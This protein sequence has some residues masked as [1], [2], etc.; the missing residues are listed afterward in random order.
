[1]VG[2]QLTV[3]ISQGLLFIALARALGPSEFGVLAGVLAISSMILPF[4]G[5]GA[6]NVMIKRFAQ[7]TGHLNTYYGNA[8]FV[9]WISA[10]I[11]IPI[12]I[13]ACIYLFE[14]TASIELVVLIC[15]SEVLFT[16][17]VDV[18]AHVHIAQERHRY[19]GLLYAVHSLA[20]LSFAL[21][22]LLMPILRTAEVWAI[23]HFCSGI[24]SA[25]FALWLTYRLVGASTT[26]PTLALKEIRLGIFFSIGLSSKSI[27]TDIDKAALAKLSTPD[28][29]GA[30]T[31]A[32]RLIYMLATP[33]RAVL[34][35]GNAK[36]FRDGKNA[37]RNSIKFAN[38]IA[39]FGALYAVFIAVLA[40]LGAPMIGIVL[41]EKYVSTI[42]VIRWLALLPLVQVIQDS[43]SDALTGA[44]FQE[45]RSLVQVAA[46]VLCIGLNI[47]LIPRYSWAGAVIATYVTQIAL[48]MAIIALAHKKI[49]D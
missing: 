29:A 21:A 9:S 11:L 10:T 1:M 2:G 3:A 33:L 49:R 39:I 7:K 19:A 4:A 25:S 44:G 8:L 12:A 34:I 13:L 41:G 14:N 17:I 31:A 32:F 5:L 46:A 22:F 15:I 43:Y 48:A 36:F 20:R 24:V 18:A 42:E 30:Y 37:S 40:W 38:K 16:K 28:V 23:F 27:Y 26:N 35:A 6:A 45:F 47:A